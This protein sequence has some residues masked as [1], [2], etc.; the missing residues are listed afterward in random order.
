MKDVCVE[1]EV[2]LITRLGNFDIGKYWEETPKDA[3]MYLFY[4]MGEWHTANPH[5]GFGIRDQESYALVQW[6]LVNK[7]GST[8]HYTKAYTCEALQKLDRIGG[9]DSVDLLNALIGKRY[10]YM[11]FDNK[12]E[13]PVDLE[14]YQKPWYELEKT[15]GFSRRFIPLWVHEMDEL[16]DMQDYIDHLEELDGHSEKL[17]KI[18]RDARQSFIKDLPKPETP[19]MYMKYN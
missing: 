1:F 2:R 15:Y 19:D 10:V 16:D 9:Y 11:A 13:E 3:L 14:I 17:V 5:H 8:I 6:G 18:L 12:T 4:R 7:K